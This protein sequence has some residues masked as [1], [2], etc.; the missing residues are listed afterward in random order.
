[1][2]QIPKDILQE[3]RDRADILQVIGEYTQLKKAGVNYKGLCPF[4]SEKTPSFNVNA[5]QSFFKCFGCGEGG[6]VYAFLMKIEGWSFPEAAHHLAKRVGVDIP[7]TSDEEAEAARRKAQARALYQELQDTARRWYERQLWQGDDPAGRDYL[8]GRG[9]DEETSRIFGLGYAP[10]AWTA[11]LDYL[12]TRR[13]GPELVERAGLA[14]RG[15]R[16]GFYDRFRGRVMFPVID[17]WGKTLAFGGRRVRDDDDKA[18]AKYI[19]SPETRF[20][21]K[22]SE[23][24]GLAATKKEIRSLGHAVL[25]EGNFDVI[26]LHAQGI[27]NAVCPMGTALTDRQVRL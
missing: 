5:D 18:G 6:D 19:N 10:Q 11:T 7:E 1:M 22:G 16:S 24:Y 25:V 23:L 14:I 15:G 27:R 20:Y 12:H 3:I 9:I 21:H 17:I 26:A 13:M 4:H 8:A 2:G